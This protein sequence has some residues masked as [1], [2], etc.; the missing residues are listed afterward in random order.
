MSG[1]FDFDT[2]PDRRGGDSH[3]WNKFARTGPDVIAAWLADMDFPPPPA[4]VDAVV[5]RVNGPALGYSEPPQDLA[6]VILQRLENL[7]NR[8]QDEKRSPAS[9]A[10]LGRVEQGPALS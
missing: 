8:G 5:K 9:S 2:V 10:S 3:K 4:V 6:D 1:Q 7:Y